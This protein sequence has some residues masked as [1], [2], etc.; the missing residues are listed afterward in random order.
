MHYRLILEIIDPK[1]TPE[2][3]SE[4]IIWSKLAEILNIGLNVRN[5]L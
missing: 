1:M 4:D 2:V 3:P 5:E